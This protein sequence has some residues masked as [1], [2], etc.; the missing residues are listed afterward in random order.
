MFASEMRVRCTEEEEVEVVN[1]C[2]AVTA[3]ADFPPVTAL[4]T[5]QSPASGTD[6]AGF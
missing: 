4:L 1:I 6:V 3:E 2:A 5:V